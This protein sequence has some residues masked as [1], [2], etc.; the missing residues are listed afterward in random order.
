[1]ISKYFDK[2]KDPLI[3]LLLGSAILSVLVGQ[4]DITTIS[5]F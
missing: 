5:R 3:L 1:M 4:V 2:F